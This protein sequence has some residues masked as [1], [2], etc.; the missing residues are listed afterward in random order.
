MANKAS[1]KK[2][3]DIIAEN[4]VEEIYVAG[5][6]GDYCVGNSIKDL[7]EARHGEK[8][9]VL[10]VLSETLTMELHYAKS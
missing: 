4:G 8:I 1:A 5:L 2:L 6:C 3:L 7:V 9:R 10:H